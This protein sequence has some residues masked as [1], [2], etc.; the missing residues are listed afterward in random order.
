MER[1]EV[2]VSVI[3]ASAML[4]H[5]GKMIDFGWVLCPQSQMAFAR[6]DGSVLD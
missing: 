3:I 6:V 5:I 2:C 4:G 1:G